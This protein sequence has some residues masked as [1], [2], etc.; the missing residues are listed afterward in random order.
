MV[1]EW[2]AHPAIPRQSNAARE[3]GGAL[4]VKFAF[5]CI[6]LEVFAA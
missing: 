2:V 3:I 1:L 6:R 5:I 4:F